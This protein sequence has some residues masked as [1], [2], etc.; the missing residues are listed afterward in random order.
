MTRYYSW[1]LILLIGCCGYSTRSTL[2]SQYKSIAIPVV[3]NQTVKPNLGDMLTDQ[4]LNDF[5]KDRNLSIA[6]IDRADIVL[7]CRITNY[8]RSPQSYTANQEVITYRTTLNVFVK[9]LDK[10]KPDTE[11]LHDGEISAWIT[12]DAQ[13]ETEE[14]GIARAIE[15]VSIEILRKL[16]TTW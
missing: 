3:D 14:I 11:P 12:Y 4:L 8:E 5:T 13:S 9:A 16:L 2:P 15:K 10:T 6:P 7:E 1:I